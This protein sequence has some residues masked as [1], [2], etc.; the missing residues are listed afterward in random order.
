M[1]LDADLPCGGGG[2]FDDGFV[3]GPRA[4]PRGVRRAG[5]TPSTTLGPRRGARVPRATTVP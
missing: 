4:L 1:R 5:G 3:A 2:R